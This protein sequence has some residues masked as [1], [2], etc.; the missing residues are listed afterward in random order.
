MAIKAR[1]P[2]SPTETFAR[3]APDP[4]IP[5]P[6]Q[7]VRIHPDPK[8][9][10]TYL[11]GYVASFYNVLLMASFVPF[12]VYFMLSWRDHLRRSFL[13]LF[14]GADRHVAGKAWEGVA[15]MARGYVLGN[16]VLGLIL[17]LITCIFFYAIGLPYWPIVGPVSGFFSLV[18]YVGLPL[19]IVPPI[20]SGLTSFDQP[21]MYILIA[22]VIALLHLIAMNLLYPKVVG[23]RVHL[24]P[25]VVT[26]AP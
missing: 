21:G 10:W 3:N 12:L 2:P 6:I 19:S 17:S 9:I 8:P 23:S 14:N 26:V 20:L 25:L 5:P 7:E 15:D 16:F 13:Y 18:P 4:A 24:N 1:P 11:Y 22:V